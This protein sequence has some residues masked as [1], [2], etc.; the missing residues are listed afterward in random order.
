M[1]DYCM[2]HMSVCIYLTTTITL[3]Q[4]SGGN[5]VINVLCDTASLNKRS[6]EVLLKIINCEKL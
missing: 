1:V 3:L 5:P 4:N 2:S 6:T